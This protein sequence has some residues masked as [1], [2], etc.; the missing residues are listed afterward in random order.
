MGKWKQQKV[1]WLAW[2]PAEGGWES[3]TAPTSPR[4]SQQP[5]QGITLDGTW[6][7]TMIQVSDTAFKRLVYTEGRGLVALI[8][9]WLRQNLQCTCA[10]EKTMCDQL[11]D[12]HYLYNSSTDWKTNKSTACRWCADIQTHHHKYHFILIL[13]WL[14]LVLCFFFFSSLLQHSRTSR[15]ST[16]AKQASV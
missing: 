13:C 8:P 16:I 1:K 10:S 15:I 9:L 12:M 11:S 2:N 7:V 6:T 5:H 3:G 14:L 4:K